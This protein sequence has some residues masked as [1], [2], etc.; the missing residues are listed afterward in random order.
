[1]TPDTT[2]WD[3]AMPK[4]SKDETMVYVFIKGEWRVFYRD[5]VAQNMISA[6]LTQFQNL[7]ND[8][9]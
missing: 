9:K 2:N 1:M 4:I 8:K 3:R 6:A 7:Q 5:D